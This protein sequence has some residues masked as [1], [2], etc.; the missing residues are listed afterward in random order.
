MVIKLGLDATAWFK[1]KIDRSHVKAMTYAAEVAFFIWKWTQV[2]RRSES[3]LF[4]IP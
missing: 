2:N 3:Q 1:K 4:F